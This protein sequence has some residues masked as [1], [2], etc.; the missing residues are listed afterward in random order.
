VDFGMSAD[1]RTDEGLLDAVQSGDESSPAFL[2]ERHGLLRFA[3]SKHLLP[4]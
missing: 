1:P 4:P 3:Q 2:V